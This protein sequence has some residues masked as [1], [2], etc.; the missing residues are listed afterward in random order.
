MSSEPHAE[1]IY[2]ELPDVLSLYADIFD[3]DDRGAKDQLRNDE[4]LRSSLNRPRTFAHSGNADIA[5][6]AA[7]LAHGIAEGQHFLEGNK[8]VALVAMRTFLAVNGYGVDA[9]QEERADWIL[10]L[11]AGLSVEGLADRIRR[12]LRVQPPASEEG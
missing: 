3:L 10:S 2:L 9:P 7:A 5:L 12:A 1:L 4:G 6:Q 8:R 11:S